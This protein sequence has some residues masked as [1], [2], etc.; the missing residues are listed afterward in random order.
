MTVINAAWSQGEL[1]SF[2]GLFQ[3]FNTKVQKYTAV[4]NPT[5]RYILH[6][7]G[8]VA[9]IWLRDISGGLFK[10]LALSSQSSTIQ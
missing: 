7:L 2:M 8:A 9:V 6:K 1:F 4:Q 10:H 3:G 5:E